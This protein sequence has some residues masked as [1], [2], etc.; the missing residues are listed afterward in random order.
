MELK[1]LN[2]L[3]EVLNKIDQFLNKLIYYFTLG[4]FGVR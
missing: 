3:D 1:I 2:R 4:N